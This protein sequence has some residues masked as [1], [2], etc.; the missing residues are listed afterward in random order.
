MELA[1]IIGLISLGYGLYTTRAAR[2][3]ADSGRDL[4]ESE[5]KRRDGRREWRM[6][7]IAQRFR[8]ARTP[9]PPGPR[10]GSPG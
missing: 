4:D 3:I 9:E 8:R 6:Q 7:L 1:I 10:S 5:Q 2:Q